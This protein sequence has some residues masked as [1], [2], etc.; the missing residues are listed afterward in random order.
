MNISNVGSITKNWSFS[1]IYSFL[2]SYLLLSILPIIFYFILKPLSIYNF[3]SCLQMT[4]AIEVNLKTMASNFSSS[5]LG[6][7][8]RLVNC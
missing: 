7:M 2:T 5:F 8:I 6:E 3:I 4:S 1:L